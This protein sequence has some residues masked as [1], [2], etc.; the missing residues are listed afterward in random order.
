MEAP[1]ETAV[2]RTRTQSNFQISPTD[3]TGVYLDDGE[4]HLN[5]VFAVN[6]LDPMRIANSDSRP[7]DRKSALFKPGAEPVDS[8]GSHVNWVT[9][10]RATT[11]NPVFRLKRKALKLS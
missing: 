6:T 7:A 10:A 5:L 4:D 3:L 1:W 8:L 2:R 11:E 9:D